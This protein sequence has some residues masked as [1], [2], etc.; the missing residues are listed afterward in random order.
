V[1][2][3]PLVSV[4]C[5]CHNH[6]RFVAEAI[7]SVLDQTYPNL[8][9]IIVDDGSTDNSVSVIESVVGKKSSIAFLKHEIPKGNCRAFNEAFRLAKGKYIIDFATDDVLLTDRIELQVDFFENLDESY[10]VVF[11]NALYIDQT[12]AVIRDHYDYLL[13][14]GLLKT[15]PQGDVYADV[16]STYFIASPTMM[17]RKTVL[18]ELDGYDEN[19]AYEDF[20]FW[21]RASRNH[22]FGFMNKI[23]TKIRR[24][25]NSMSTR[26]YQQGDLQLHSTYLVCRKAF[27]LNRNER[28]HDALVRRLRYEIRQSVF[29]ENRREAQLFYELLKEMKRSNLPYEFMNLLNRLKL[30]LRWVRSLYYKLKYPDFFH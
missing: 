23:T 14:R 6:E 9:I 25:I 4:I 2:S 7:H 22:K 30:P 29:S 1:I 26:L 19:L 10:G 5:L 27:Q 8:E 24:K 13:K 28:E 15:I 16:L 21:V 17:I 3:K 11:S 20:D 12:G 18:D